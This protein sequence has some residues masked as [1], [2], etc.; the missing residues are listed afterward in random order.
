[1]CKECPKKPKKTDPFY[2]LPI[3]VNILTDMEKRKWVR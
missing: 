3:S 1:M 2:A